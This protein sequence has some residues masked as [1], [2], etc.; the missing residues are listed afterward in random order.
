MEK[1]K[2]KI[3]RKMTISERISYFLVF[4][5]IMPILLVVITTLCIIGWPLI[6]L[7][8]IDT[9]DEFEGTNTELQ[10]K[11]KELGGWSYIPED[12]NNKFDA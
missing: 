4:P 12:P 3:K 5:V 2:V 7:G 9:E 6:L 10:E 8:Y 1:I 11:I